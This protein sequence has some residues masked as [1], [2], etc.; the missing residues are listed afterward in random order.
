MV[1]LAKELLLLG[2]DAFIACSGLR[3]EFELDGVRILQSVPDVFL[4]GYRTHG[5][6]NSA[7]L[8]REVM[9]NSL[10]KDGFVALG[11]YVDAQLAEIEADILHLNGFA[12][13]LFASAAQ[14]SVVTNHENDREYDRVW[15]DGATELMCA[16]AHLPD[17]K[18]LD[19]AVLTTPSQY[20]AGDFSKRLK[21]QVMQL[22]AGV[23]LETFPVVGSQ[24][25]SSGYT[26]ILLPSRFDPEQKGHDVAITAA[27][28][29]KRERFPFH[30]T[31]SGVRSDYEKRVEPFR[32]QARK[33]GVLDSITFKRFADIRIA[34]RETDIVISP[35]R[36]CSYGLSISEALAL[37]IPTV[38]SSIPTY[39][40]IASGFDHAYLVPADDAAALANTIMRVAKQPSASSRRETVRFRVEN[41]LRNM[42]RQCHAIYGSI[43]HSRSSFE[44]EHV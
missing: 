37:G 25:N 5:L 33:M 21:K 24:S 26:Q 15:G 30:I 22:K 34:Y 31:F 9:G 12:T 43:N 23:R 8:K 3:R 4:N 32:E 42:A 39:R 2:Y 36:Y 11:A 28:I 1:E 10:S 44:R 35:E 18:L 17:A 20:Y 13:S 7:F 27:Q 19:A 14:G 38:L 16:L 29:L 6:A 41:D 40:E